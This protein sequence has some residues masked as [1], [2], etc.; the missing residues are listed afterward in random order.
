VIAAQL[1]GSNEIEIWGDGE[2]TRSFT[3]IEDTI[4]GI[5]RLYESDVS[6]PINLG[7]SQLVTINGLV[8]I[9]EEIAGVKLERRYN[10]SAP[11]GVRGRNSDNTMILDRLGWEP[12]TSLEAGMAKTYHWIHEQMV[13][14]AGDRAALAVE[15]I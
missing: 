11:Q 15:A 10:R 14:G 9:V 2:Q 13:S 1:N 4:D 6:E 5:F 12:G 7:S 3:F 8:D